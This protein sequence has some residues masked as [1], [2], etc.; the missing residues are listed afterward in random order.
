MEE[1]EV[2]RRTARLCRVEELQPEVNW[3]RS[4]SLARIKELSP[5]Q[6]SVLFKLLHQPLPRESE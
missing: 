3:G 5:D 1:D 6:K 2:G 4:L